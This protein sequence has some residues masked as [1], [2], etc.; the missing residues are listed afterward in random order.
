M[1]QTAE[2]VATLR[3]I[4]RERQDEWGVSSQNRAEKAIADGFF[5]REIAPVTLRDGTVVSK[6]DGPRAG[7][8]ARGAAR[9]STRSSASRAPSPPATA[10]RSTTAPPRWSS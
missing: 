1:G 8:T 2:N 7:V 9:A 10:A 6:D 5:E 4:S 3:G